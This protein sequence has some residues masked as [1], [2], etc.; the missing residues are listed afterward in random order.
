MAEGNGNGN[1]SAD[2]AAT[3]VITYNPMT[4]KLQMQVDTPSI[5]ST[6]AVLAQAMRFWQTQEDELV[7]QQFQQQ[8]VEAQ[9][10]A[11]IRDRVLRKV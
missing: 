2:Q 6:I 4:L 5:G 7:R 9:Q 8:Q 10:N 11:I 3:I 1:G